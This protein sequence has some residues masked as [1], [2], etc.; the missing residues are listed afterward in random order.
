MKWFKHIASSLDDP[1]IEESIQLFKGDGYLVFF[2][3]LEIMADEFDIKNP[4]IVRLPLRHITKRLQ[5]SPRKTLEILSFFGKKERKKAQISYTIDGHYITLNC[6][7]LRELCDEWTKK[8]LRSKDG[9]DTDKLHPIEEE[10]EIEEEKEI[11]ITNNSMFDGF[12]L[13]EKMSDKTLRFWGN[14][15][16]GIIFDRKDK[17]FIG[18]DNELIGMWK[19]ACPAVDI[20]LEVTKARNW[21]V[22]KGGKAKRSNYKSFLGGWMR[23]TQER[24]GSNNTVTQPQQA[25]VESIFPEEGQI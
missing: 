19:E 2:G 11:D 5:L 18:I 24:G 3:V 4:G 15:K 25:C 17:K 13:K 21:I 22:E 7:K 12:N 16:N 10:E 20:L 8:Q 23:R 6:P 14:P 9:E 1:D